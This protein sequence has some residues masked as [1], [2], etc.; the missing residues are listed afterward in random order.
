MWKVID[1]AGCIKASTRGAGLDDPVGVTHGGTGRTTWPQ[2]SLIIA[3]DADSLAPFGKDPTGFKAVSFFSSDSVPRYRDVGDLVQ[4]QVPSIAARETGNRRWSIWEASIENAAM[5][6]L[7]FTSTNGSGGTTVVDATSSWRRYTTS[8]AD[9]T[10][11]AGNGSSGALGRPTHSPRLKAKFRTGSDITN[12]RFWFGLFNPIPSGNSDDQSSRTGI[13]ITYSSVRGDSGFLTWVGTGVGETLGTVALSSIAASTVYVIELQIVNPPNG[14]PTAILTVNGVSQTIQI[15]TIIYT[16]STAPNFTSF[17]GVKSA[18]AGATK[19]LDISVMMQQL[20]APVISAS[21][22]PIIHWTGPTTGQQDM[23]VNPLLVLPSASDVVNGNYTITADTDMTVVVQGFAGGGAAQDESN[24]ATGRGGGGGGAGDETGET[25]V[26]DHTKTYSGRAGAGGES[27]IGAPVLAS[28]AG[29]DTFFKTTDGAT[30]YLYLTGGHAAVGSTA[31]AG[32]AATTGANAV[33]GGNGG[34][35]NAGTG[36]NG[37]GSAGGAGGGGGAGGTTGPGAGGNGGSSNDGAGA[38][39]GAAGASG[40]GD[41]GVY[42]NGGEA[43]SGGG[44]GGGGGRGGKISG[45]S[46][47]Y[48]GGGG[49]AAGLAVAPFSNSGG[50]GLQG[51]L[52]IKFVS[53]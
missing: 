28:T 37:T 30:T 49:G 50:N 24:N 8:A 18:D 1:S 46:G 25:V 17:L 35:G 29:G 19:F 3:D 20:I 10:N 31:G 21:A 41:A 16:F 51:V 2:G 5:K 6:E 52:V 7:G 9:T 39:G 4:T 32:G 11:L 47:N 27:H 53:Q 34:A 42:G 12:Y 14:I 22:A 36:S 43:H 23:S 15:P 48:G 38:A 13:G 44:G 40:S 45:V 33:A 26:L